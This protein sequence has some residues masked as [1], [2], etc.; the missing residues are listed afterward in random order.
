MFSARNYK[1]CEIHNF[2][3]VSGVVLRVYEWMCDNKLDAQD[4]DHETEI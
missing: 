3:A 2:S 1:C 4:G